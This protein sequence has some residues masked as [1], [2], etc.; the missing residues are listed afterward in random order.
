MWRLY[1]KKRYEVTF[2]YKIMLLFTKKNKKK[3]GR[4]KYKKTGE[5]IQHSENGVLKMTE[6]RKPLRVI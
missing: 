6:G 1:E 2:H 5:L 3:I 4:E